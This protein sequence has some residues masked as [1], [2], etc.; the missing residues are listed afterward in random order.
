[1]Y[2]DYY[3]FLFNDHNEQNKGGLG[4]SIV[5]IVCSSYKIAT[6]EAVLDFYNFKV[7]LKICQSSFAVERIIFN[8]Y[9]YKISHFKLGTFVIDLFR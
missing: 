2:P 7:T 1:M 5:R 3:Y 9:L 4:I 6:E 8:F